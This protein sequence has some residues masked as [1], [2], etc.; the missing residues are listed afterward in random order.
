MFC[1][2]IRW[3]RCLGETSLRSAF[4]GS[5]VPSASAARSLPSHT[6]GSGSHRV[7]SLCA[8]LMFLFLF[9][10]AV[11]FFYKQVWNFHCNCFPL[12]TSGCL[13]CTKYSIWNQFYSYKISGILKITL[14]VNLRAECQM[15]LWFV[16]DWFFC[17]PHID[18]ITDTCSRVWFSVVVRHPS[19]SSASF[20]CLSVLC[21]F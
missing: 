14:C 10:V 19:H 21:C 1:D 15:F 4:R 5:D 2:Q 12:N 17:L 9:F 16:Y 7:C 3:I 8:I 18:W 11:K 13:L 6:G 20:M